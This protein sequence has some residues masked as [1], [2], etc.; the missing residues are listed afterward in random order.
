MIHQIEQLYTENLTAAAYK[1][2]IVS[3][4]AGLHNFSNLTRHTQLMLILQALIFPA[5]PTT[6]PRSTRTMKAYLATPNNKLAAL[7][8]HMLTHGPSPAVEGMDSIVGMVDTPELAR[9]EAIQ[10][11]EHCEA[12]LKNVF[13]MAI[14]VNARARTQGLSTADAMRIY[15]ETQPG[16]NYCRRGGRGFLSSPRVLH[17]VW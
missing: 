11:P 6:Q 3:I 16:G 4:L 13:G 9:L 5:D 1:A 8:D 10:N 12:C 14:E 7:R 17:V 2:R 15:Y